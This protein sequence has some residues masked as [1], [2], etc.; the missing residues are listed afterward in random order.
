MDSDHPDFMLGP[1]LDAL[2][3]REY[4]LHSA[5]DG[6]ALIEFAVGTIGVGEIGWDSG[7]GIFRFQLS[8]TA[9]SGL[10]R[11]C[12]AAARQFS[13]L[14]YEISGTKH[15]LPTGDL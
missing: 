13:A 15:P 8:L 2:E 1:E 12:L 10:G 5:E 7:P 11:E 6:S 9:L 14:N 3:L 4:Q